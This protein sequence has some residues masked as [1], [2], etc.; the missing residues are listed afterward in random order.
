MNKS[1]ILYRALV[2]GVIAEVV[3][4]ALSFGLYSLKYGREPMEP[5]FN[6]TATALQMPGIMVS[7]YLGSY[8]NYSGWWQW[9]IV[10]FVQTLVWTTIGFVFRLRRAR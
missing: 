6:W 10:F 4:L 7:D 5:P 2:S 1:Q 8:V 3:C 9:G